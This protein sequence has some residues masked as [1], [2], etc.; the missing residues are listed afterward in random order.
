M[1]MYDRK[2]L[3]LFRHAKSD[4]DADYSSDHERPLA[5]RGKNAAKTMGAILAGSGKLPEQIICSTAVRARQTLE[6]ACQ[7]GKWNTTIEYS[8]Q[9]YDCTPNSM[10]DLLKRSDNVAGSVMFVGHEPSCSGLISL[11][12]G[13]GNIRFPTAAM[14]RIDFYLDDWR[15]LGA[16]KGQ[17]RWLLQPR[18][19]RQ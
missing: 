10:I 19:F 15:S 16:D 2:S 3:F 14:A 4:W 12:I 5:K 6:L 8:D 7:S 11:L 13:G 1:L 17:L 18:F 9:L